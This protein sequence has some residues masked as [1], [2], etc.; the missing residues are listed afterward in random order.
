MKTERKYTQYTHKKKV[1]EKQLKRRV[2]FLLDISIVAD[3]DICVHFSL[4]ATNLIM[5][6]H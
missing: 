6:V 2:G 4:P 3:D 5:A 1:S